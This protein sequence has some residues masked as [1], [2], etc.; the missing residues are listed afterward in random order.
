MKTAI[1][2]SDELFAQADYLARQSN[3]SRSQIFRDALREYLFRHAPDKVTE[4][5]NSVVDTI[6]QPI[7]DFV[8]ITARRTLERNEW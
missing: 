2:L 8:K 4:S 5:M 1:S 3:K 7:D 6:D